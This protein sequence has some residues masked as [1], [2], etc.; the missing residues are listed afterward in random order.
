[1]TRTYM[2]ILAECKYKCSVC[3]REVDYNREYMRF[4]HIDGDRS[5]NSPSNLQPVCCV[6]CAIKNLSKI[7]KYQGLTNMLYNLP[8]E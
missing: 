5:N 7:K 1:M 2:K 8:K 3:S 6:C 4:Y